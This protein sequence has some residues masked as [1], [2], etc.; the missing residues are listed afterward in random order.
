MTFLVPPVSLQEFYK[1]LTM[2]RS[3]WKHFAVSVLA[4]GPLAVATVL[5]QFRHDRTYQRSPLHFS[6]QHVTVFLA[7][8]WAL[9]DALSQVF[10]KNVA[11]RPMTLV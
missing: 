6:E 2:S 1:E 8:R 5:A 3:E 7:V 9:H 10:P 11:E 4:M